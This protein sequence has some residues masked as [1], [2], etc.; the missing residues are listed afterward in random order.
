MPTQPPSKPRKRKKYKPRAPGK[1]AR[2]VLEIIKSHW[3]VT[4]GEIMERWTYEGNIKTGHSRFQYNLKTL[5]RAGLIEVKKSG[6]RVL[7]AWPKDLEKLRDE[8]VRNG[9]LAM[10]EGMMQVLDSRMKERPKARQ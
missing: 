2:M 4:I 5:Q 1:S 7:I 3:P 10:R 6:P 8:G 9:L